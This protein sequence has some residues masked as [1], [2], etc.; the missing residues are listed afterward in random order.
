MQEAL[1]PGGWG[2]EATLWASPPKGEERDW[3]WKG[4]VPPPR[5]G[6]GL[7]LVLTLTLWKEESWE[8]VSCRKPSQEITLFI[9]RA[10]GVRVQGWNRALPSCDKPHIPIGG[11]A[12]GRGG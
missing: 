10:S 11:Q 9:R 6:V 5:P 2:A 4:W 8:P 12:P 1:T 7:V 3:W